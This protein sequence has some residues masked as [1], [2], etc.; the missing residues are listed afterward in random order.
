MKNERL[1]ELIGE[2]NEQQVIE[3][4]TY[5]KSKKSVYLKWGTMAACIAL[6]LG[7]CIGSFA[8]VAEAKEYKAAV[9]FFNDYNMSTEALTRSEIKAV[10]RDIITKS[11]NYS[12]TVYIP[13]T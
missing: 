10:Y 1:Y 12:K 11:F 4:M 2:I 5:K 9:Q 13:I 6:L 8:F 7:V 3:A